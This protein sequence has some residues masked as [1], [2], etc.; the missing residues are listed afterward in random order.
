[1]NYRIIY[2]DELYHHGVKG[3]KWGVRR[4]TATVGRQRSTSDGRYSSEQRKSKMKKAAKIGAMVAGTALVAYGGYRIYK[5]KGDAITSLGE[6]YCKKGHET[7]RKAQYQQTLASEWANQS[8]RY[9]ISA[10]TAKNSAERSIFLDAS[11]SIYKSATEKRAESDRTFDEAFGYINK[12]R[13][14]NYSRKEVAG[15]MRN[16]AKNRLKRR[17]R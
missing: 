5:L 13:N 16:I 11:K 3:M 6:K 8:D 15:E 1:M 9:K 17:G 4:Q 10:G 14:K 12:A 7:W 2:N